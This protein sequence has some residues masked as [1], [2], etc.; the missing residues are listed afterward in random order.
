MKADEIV[1]QDLRKAF[2]GLLV[3]ERSKDTPTVCVAPSRRTL[4]PDTG[5][6][7]CLAGLLAF[8]DTRFKG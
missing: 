8:K 7:D 4:S 1:N 2:Q 3:A 5:L 6:R